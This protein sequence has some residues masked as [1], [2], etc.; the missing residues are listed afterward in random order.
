MVMPNRADVRVLLQ[1]VLCLIAVYS[2]A[3]LVLPAKSGD[4]SSSTST[5]AITFTVA[6]AGLASS[7]AYN[8]T[9]RP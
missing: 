7:L 4:G 8:P 5:A 3:S 6:V 9:P 2:A 1:A